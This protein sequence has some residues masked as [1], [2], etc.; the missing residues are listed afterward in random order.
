M[1]SNAK[2]IVNI[3]GR[4]LKA[5]NGNVDSLQGKDIWREMGGL[6]SPR[7]GIFFESDRYSIDD[8]C[9]SILTVNIE[10]GSNYKLPKAW[11]VNIIP[12]VSNNDVSVSLINS[13]S[14][15]PDKEVVAKITEA[16]KTAEGAA[17]EASD[18]GQM[19]DATAAQ[20]RYYDMSDVA[21]EMK[22][23]KYLN[24]SFRLNIIAP[25]EDILEQS[26]QEI[27]INYRNYFNKIS[28]DPFVG[29][30]QDDFRDMFKGADKQLG[31]NYKMTSSEIAGLSPF[32]T[33]GLED[34]TGVF[35]GTLAADVNSG[36]VMLDTQ[37]FNQLSVVGGTGAA[38]LSG[39]K[40][41]NI[42]KASMWGIQFAQ[43]AL[44]TGANV[45]HVVLNSA[46]PLAYGSDLRSI[47]KEIRM[48]RGQLNMLELFGDKKD[49]LRLFSVLMEKIK[50]MVKQ[51]RP[52]VTLNQLQILGEQI[53]K[54]Y[55]DEHKW[56]P[57]AKKH[58]DELRLIGIPS[59]QVPKFFMISA[60]FKKAINEAKLLGRQ[61]SPVEELET[62]KMFRG[63]FEELNNQYGDLF[64]VRTT[65]NTR[66]IKKTPQVVYRLSDLRKRGDGVFLSQ[67]VNTFSYLS[68]NIDRDDVVIV[69]GAELL[70]Q[71][72]MAYMKEQISYYWS[73]GVKVVLL[74]DDPS[75][76]FDQ[77]LFDSAET[78]IVG[79][80]SKSVMD[81]YDSKLDAPLPSTVRQ[82]LVHSGNEGIYFVR[83]GVNSALFN[84]ESQL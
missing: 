59:S 24:I 68:G 31:H 30:Q 20:Q 64:N 27:E 6:L 8:K 81:K 16:T 29:E 73:K 58:L 76:M 77:D 52:E 84:W 36:A 67:V 10:P 75:V 33:R 12:V 79:N 80:L 83:R 26:I 55:I 37:L 3:T 53:E 1:A 57:N 51:L 21:A 5:L 66:L 32:I 11:G 63:L 28:I 40:Y 71:S 23:D 25:S 38:I 17:G 70:S 34:S 15:I 2:S 49:E 22:S 13:F 60:Y 61:G 41:P 14:V 47:S 42:S 62:L 35:V 65:I 82:E 46:D 7:K 45:H 9:G 48:D 54:F 19:L 39:K 74:Y 18:M 44:I 50:L 78:V 56:V 69:H 4:E 43:D 72:V